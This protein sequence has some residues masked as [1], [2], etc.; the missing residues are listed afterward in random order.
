MATLGARA[1]TVAE[2][3]LGVREQ[4]ARSNS[5]PRVREYQAATWLPGTGWPW[6]AAF[7][8][9]AY[10][11]A[12]YVFPD[13]SAGAWD[14]VDRAVR[15]GWGVTVT[16]ATARPG[17]LVAFR[18]GSGHVALFARYDA[19]AG[20]VHTVDGN[21]S[22]MVARRERPV[23]Q[24]YRIVAVRGDRGVPTPPS[25]RPMWEIV[26]GE[27]DR[28]RVVFTSRSLD[29]TIGRA[30]RLLSRGAN[31]LRIRRARPPAQKGR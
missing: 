24:V 11:Q 25:P 31:G 22:D 13:R 21:V 2:G 15:N 9:W 30:A 3:E 4:P 28:A 19:R 26:R 23:G 10:K 14:L 8:C 7:C 5:G 18:A 6:C 17:D 27:G 1:L 29:A 12:G 20:T 16:A